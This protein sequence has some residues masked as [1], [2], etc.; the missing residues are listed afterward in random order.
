[1]TFTLVRSVVNLNNARAQEADLLKRIEEARILTEEL[2]AKKEFMGTL[3]YV[4]RE[5]RKE[6]GMSLP[7]TIRYAFSMDTSSV[8]TMSDSVDF[9]TDSGI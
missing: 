2:M 9:D 7:G 6:W 1:M 4:E 8:A 5:A 3:Q